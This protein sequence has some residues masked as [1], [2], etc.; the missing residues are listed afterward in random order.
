MAEMF[1][2]RV[3]SRK[4]EVLGDD[5][6][7]SDGIP[8]RERSVN[9][10]AKGIVGYLPSLPNTNEFD[11]NFDRKGFLERCA[12]APT[13]FILAGIHFKG[14]Y[15]WLSLGRSPTLITEVY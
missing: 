13:S 7:R 9:Y 2:L 15:W 10:D 12:L 1:D 11:I 6:N 3:E 14:T 4:G 8:R 5:T